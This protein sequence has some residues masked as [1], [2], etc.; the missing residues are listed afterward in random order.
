VGVAERVF[1]SFER[2]NVD[3]A[4]PLLG[5]AGEQVMQAFVVS[6]EGWVFAEPGVDGATVNLGFAR[7][8][9]DGFAGHELGHD[10][11]LFGAERGLFR[12]RHHDHMVTGGRMKATPANAVNKWGIGR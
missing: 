10:L 4:D 2:G 9:G 6:A 8:F 11:E 3:F 1:K 5:G 12:V 7:G